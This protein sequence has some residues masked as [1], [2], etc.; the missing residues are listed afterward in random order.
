MA[1]INFGTTVSLKQA[2]T[3]IASVPDARFF[4]EGEPGIGKSAIPQVLAKLLPGYNMVY[5]DC[6]TMDLGD[7]VM[8]MPNRDLRITEY[9]P[10]AGF[11]LHEGKPV[12][13]MLDEFTKA[14]QPVQNM[15][16]PLLEAKNARLG[17]II[18]PEGSIVFLTGNLSSDGVGDNLKAH[19]LNRISRIRV[20][21]PSADEWLEW[22]VNN[23]VDPI[24][25][26]WVR[27]YPHCL[28]SYL[29]DGQ[30]DNP[31]IYDPKKVQLSYVSPR[32]LERASH[33]VKQR[34][35]L[36]DDAMI[37]AMAGTIGE[38][39]SRDI[40]AF[41]T[42]QDQLEP[43]SVIIDDPKNARVPTSPGAC[44]VLVFG[45]ITKIDKET[46]T[47][48]MQ[49]MN[50]FEPEWQATFAINVAKNP[51]KQAIAFS[52]KAFADWVQQNEDLL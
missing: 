12:A 1:A 7:T 45:A 36:D 46:M 22:A 42:Y 44:A 41:V 6:S 20:R 14:M 33:I 39:A 27:Q 9:F 16:H 19:S 52:S 29:E 17:D 51:A 11:K 47:P 18:L 21:K 50:R 8:P 4:L 32:S 26:A 25:M 35:Q 48:F 15:L 28:A 38:A 37:A 49:Y 13:I 40:Q 30:K 34:A 10:S 24:I 3:L 23:N 43:W 5:R 2:A 31:Y